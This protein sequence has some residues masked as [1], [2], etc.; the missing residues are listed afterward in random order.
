MVRSGRDWIPSGWPFECPLFRRRSN[1]FWGLRMNVASDSLIS[2]RRSG[3]LAMSCNDWSMVRSS[4]LRYS[5]LLIQTRIR[6][7][8]SIEFVLSR[9]RSYI[10]SGTSFPNL[11]TGEMYFVR[12][13]LASGSSD[14]GTNSLSVLSA[15]N[16]D[17]LNQRCLLV[18]WW[19][20]RPRLASSAGL[21]VPGTYRH[22]FGSDPSNISPTRW[23][24][25][26]WIRKDL[27]CIYPRTVAESDQNAGL[28]T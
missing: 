25:K 15:R 5:S 12:C 9:I 18:S 22:W 21:R 1:F 13:D 6:M 20:W 24:A 19:G 8:C 26:V 27:D 14:A 3:S 11:A 17:P 23:P 4:R 28:Q 7:A 16:P 2:C 10:A